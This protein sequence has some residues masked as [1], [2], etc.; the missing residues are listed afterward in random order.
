MEERMM[1]ARRMTRHEEGGRG[2][3]VK[4]RWR[5]MECSSEKEGVVE[6]L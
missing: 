3:N 1:E 4:T 6:G 2:G 5:V